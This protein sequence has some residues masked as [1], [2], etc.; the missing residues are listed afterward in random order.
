ML[1]RLFW[2]A[3][4]TLVLVPAAVAAGPS[5][6][7]SQD[8]EGV[9]LP[10]GD[11]TYVA[12]ADGAG[13]RLLV[14]R[15]ADGKALRQASFAASLGIPRV[16]FD[17]TTGGLSADGRTL[18]LGD[19]S[20][21]T[22]PLRESSRFLVLDT[23]TMR[24]RT[25]VKLRG[26]FGYDALSPDGA[27]LYLVQHVS[28]ADVFRYVVRAFDVAQGRLLSGRIADRTQRGWVMQGFPVARVSSPDGRMAYTFYSNP[29][30]YPFIHA[31]DTVRGT[32]HCIGVPWHGK[33]DGLTQLRMT[34]VGNELR[35]GWPGGRTFISVD[36]R[37]YRLTHPA[38]AGAGGAFPW[39]AV[40]IG[41][42]AAL[43]GIVLMRRRRMHPAG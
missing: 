1:R 40:V 29:G 12:Q 41:G 34:L 22:G 13:T 15:D 35:L 24:P 3:L 39:W 37:T 7:V 9:Q 38:T 30:G 27:T 21:Y 43:G 19:A 28:T 17:G 25:Q 14:V 36:T 20:Q 33:Q 5:P 42:A 32:A 23:T 16:A 6:G 31:L 4:A 26:D 2:C 18:V 10:E 11:V 8:S